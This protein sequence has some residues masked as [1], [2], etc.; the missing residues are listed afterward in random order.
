VRVFSR[1]FRIFTSP[2]DSLIGKYNTGK[3]SEQAGGGIL[4]GNS[5][6]FFDFGDFAVDFFFK[7]CCL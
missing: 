3:L 5:T 7:L 1:D 2:I 4:Q 6:S